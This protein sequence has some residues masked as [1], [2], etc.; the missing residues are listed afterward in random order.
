MTG[1]QDEVKLHLLR[2][3]L[4]AED[5]QGGEAAGRAAETR[6]SHPKMERRRHVDGA[7]SLRAVSPG[8]GT[9]WT[10]ILSYKSQL[11][12]QGSVEQMDLGFAVSLGMHV[13]YMG[14]SAGVTGGTALLYGH[15][16]EL[17]GHPV[18]AVAD[19]PKLLSAGFSFAF[20]AVAAIVAV[21]A[22][23]TVVAT[24]IKRRRRQLARAREA[25]K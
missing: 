12:H 6:G 16:G 15:M 3:E 23:L 14:M 22:A 2:V 24:L 9:R 25:V 11:A 20:S 1:E 10:H 19:A 13:R 4:G 18:N 8:I 5:R 17:A 21:G 7:A